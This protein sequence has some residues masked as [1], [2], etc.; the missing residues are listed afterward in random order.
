LYLRQQGIKLLNV[1]GSFEDVWT[2]TYQAGGMAQVVECLPSKYE[3]M[4]L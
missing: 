3:L 1:D 2:L 4:Q